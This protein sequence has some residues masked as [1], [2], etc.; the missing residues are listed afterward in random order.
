MC[1][2][3][4][5]ILSMTWTRVL[6]EFDRVIGLDRLKAVHLNDSMFGLGSHKDRHAKIGEGKIGFEA[7]KRIIS[8]ASQT[9]ET[10]LLS[11]RLPMIWRG[12]AGRCHAERG[13]YMSKLQGSMSEFPAEEKV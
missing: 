7:V 12:Y 13:L 10:T 8:K 11:G 3:A 1:M 5:M 6:T 4:D 2:T 9:Q